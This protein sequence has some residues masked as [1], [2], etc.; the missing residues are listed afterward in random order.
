MYFQTIDDK[1]DCVAYY[2]DNKLIFNE[3]PKNITKTWNYAQF[4]ENQTQVEYASLY[5]DGRSL[6]EVCPSELKDEY[7]SARNTLKAFLNSIKE[8]KVDLNQSCL[9]YYIPDRVLV[10]WCEIKNKITE[11]VFENYEKPENYDYLLS[12]TK[13]LTKTKYQ[14]LNIDYSK[15]N[16]KL[17]EKRA[18]ELLVGKTPYINYNLYGTKTGRLS[19]K[20]NSFPILTMN[21][22]F[23]KIIIP[24]NNLF[25]SFDYNAYDLRILLSLSGIEQPIEDLHDWNTEK[26][27]KNKKTRE[28][29]KETMFS[30]LYD[31][32]KNNYEIEKYYDRQKILKNYWN[33]KEIKNP[34]GK[35][36]E[37]DK[38]HAINYLIQSTGA[39]LILRKALEVDEILK[40]SKSFI[41]FT[42][43]DNIVVDFAKEDKH[44]VEKIK[45]IMEKTCLGNFKV[46]ISIGKN[47]GEMIDC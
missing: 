2:C 11:Y 35:I 22:L 39:E 45:K 33:G 1:N 43:H 15:L 30:W 21:K 18:I 20:K 23:R 38:Y 10:N 7:V 3:T 32:N 29:A 14:K 47:F 24:K 40:S 6:E 44:L 5:C 46:N 41:S 42:I 36:L 13:L 26:I 8:A 34:Y 9:F 17:L 31:L 16:D 19:T 28:S 4:L 25:V 37:C 12:I 27:F